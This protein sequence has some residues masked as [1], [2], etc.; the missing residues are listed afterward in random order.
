M[1]PTSHWIVGMM[2]TR[3]SPV[4]REWERLRLAEY[5]VIETENVIGFWST[6]ALPIK[7][8]IILTTVLQCGH[9]DS[10]LKIRSH[11]CMKRGSSSVWATV[12]NNGLV[13]PLSCTFLT[14]RLVC[15]RSLC[16]TLCSPNH[17]IHVFCCVCA[18]WYTRLYFWSCLLSMLTD[19]FCCSPIFRYAV[20][21][22]IWSSL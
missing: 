8:N 15:F 19:R 1:L 11:L 18:K 17:H 7:Y 5:M 13:F 6:R 22:F 16:D 2:K 10:S 20:I 21:R 9:C 4:S 14:T 3:T 12:V